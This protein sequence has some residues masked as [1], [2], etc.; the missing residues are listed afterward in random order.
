MIERKLR[1][2]NPAPGCWCEAGGERLSLLSG[3]VVAGSGMP[4]EIVAL[5]LTIAC[6]S[7]ALEITQ[8]Q[9]AGRRPMTPEELQRGF[10][11][12]LGTRLG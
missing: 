12:P 7:D 8:V 11:L 1:A 2:L 9:R 4:G 5:P 10:P 6:G 3:R